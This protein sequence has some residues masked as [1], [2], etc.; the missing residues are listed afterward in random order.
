M[1]QVLKFILCLVRHHFYN[2]KVSFESLK[3]LN[4]FKNLLFL[5]FIFTPAKELR[6]IFNHINTT[7]NF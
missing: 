7:E 6:K 4:G 1:V 2:N 3:D 5:K